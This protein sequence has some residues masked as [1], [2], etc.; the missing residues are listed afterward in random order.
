M[1]VNGIAGNMQAHAMSGASPIAGGRFDGQLQGALGDVSSLLQMTPQQLGSSLSQSGSLSGVAGGSG[2]SEQQLID[3]IKQGLQDA[4]SK[5]TG[6][7][8]ENI[9]TRIA[10]HQ[11]LLP[12]STGGASNPS[13]GALDPATWDA[14]PG[15]TTAPSS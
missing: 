6:T 3:T 11:R 1:N 2:V 8:L 5:L 12:P 4:G 13:A 15:S 9:A 10:H 14:T 7:R